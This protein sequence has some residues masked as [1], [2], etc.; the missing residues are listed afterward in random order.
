MKTTALLLVFSLMSTTVMITI[1]QLSGEQ[2]SIMQ[3]AE[4]EEQNERKN[5]GDKKLEERQSIIDIHSTD[6]ITVRRVAKSD[7]WRYI[8]ESYV[9][10]ITPPPQIATC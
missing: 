1:I 8:S 2:V 5:S 7:I 3:F 6:A 4:E 10:I 9:G